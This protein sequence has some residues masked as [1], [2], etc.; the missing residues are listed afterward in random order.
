MKINQNSINLPV[1]FALLIHK[2][3]SILINEQKTNSATTTQSDSQGLID[4]SLTDNSTIID[5]K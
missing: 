5:D 1:Q 3:I 4:K 2:R